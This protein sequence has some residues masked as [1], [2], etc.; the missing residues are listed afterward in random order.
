MRYRRWEL[1]NIVVLVLLMALPGCVKIDIGDKVTEANIGEELIS[2]SEARE[3]GVLTELEF[4]Q[5]RRKLI[6]SL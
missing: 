4:R 6:E 3:L 2:L 1:I 5:L